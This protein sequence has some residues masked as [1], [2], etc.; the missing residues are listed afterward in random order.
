M[1][2]NIHR[3]LE[4]LEKHIPVRCQ[5]ANDNQSLVAQWVQ[6]VLQHFGEKRGPLE[7]PA[8]AVARCF[9]LTTRELD[10]LMVARANAR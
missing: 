5:A 8:E 4:V 10:S 1:R 6:D 3:R 7:S 9:G 2:K